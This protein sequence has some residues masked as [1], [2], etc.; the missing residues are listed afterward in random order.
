MALLHDLLAAGYFPKE[1]PPPFSSKSFAQ[2]LAPVGGT[3]STAFRRPKWARPVTFTIAKPQGLRRRLAIVNPIHFYNQS[4]FVSSEWNLLSTHINFSPLSLSKPVPDVSGL[5]ALVPGTGQSD[6]LQSRSQSRSMGKYTLVADISEF[7]PSIYT[8]SIPWALHGKASAKAN[9][10]SRTLLGNRFDK[11]LRDSQEGQTVGI[12]IGPDIS[13]VTAEVVLTAI[14]VQLDAKFKNKT[15]FRW[16][17]EFEMSFVDYRSAE[18]G[19]AE[20]QHTLADFELRLNPRKTS[21]S[22]APFGYESTWVHELRSFELAPSVRKQARDLVRFFDL[23]FEHA[24]KNR[25]DHVVRYALARLRPTKLDPTNWLLYQQLLSHA[26]IHELTVT[27]QY[28][29]NLLVGQQLGLTV[30]KSL[31]E[32]ALNF[33]IERSAL[34]EQHHETAWALWG[35]LAFGITLSNKAA[36]AIE[37]V[38]NSVVALLCLDAL[39]QSLLPTTFSTT[40]WAGRMTAPDLSGEQWLLAYE[41]NVKNWLPTVGG[42]DHVTSDPHFSQLKNLGVEFYTPV[43]R[44]ALPPTSIVPF[45]IPGARSV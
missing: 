28:I 44:P 40:A 14:D 12:A 13:L 36:A 45:A 21:I 4:L 6:L 15:F 38:E 25:G 31:A 29:T 23:V 7:Y 30:D 18:E 17:D 37:K 22:S 11:L 35:M 41:A 32:S 5:R 24:A 42:G 20:L 10:R 16:M 43:T 1:L 3:A 34:L 27:D 8:H 19:L 26:M 39:Q 2:R 33:V 9:L